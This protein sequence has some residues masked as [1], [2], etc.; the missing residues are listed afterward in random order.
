M[1]KLFFRFNLVGIICIGVGVAFIIFNIP[2]YMWL[3]LLGICLILTGI[4]LCR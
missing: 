4:F 2:V 3:I 1:K